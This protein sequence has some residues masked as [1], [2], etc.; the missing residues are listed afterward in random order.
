MFLAGADSC[1]VFTAQYAEIAEKEHRRVPLKRRP[2]TNL[3][4]F[5][6]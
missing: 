1:S 5:A 3:A 6:L 2:D 4:F